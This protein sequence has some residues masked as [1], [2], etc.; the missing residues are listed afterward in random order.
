MALLDLMMPKIGL[1]FFQTVTMLL[2]LFLMKRLAWRHILAFIKEQEQ[3][4]AKAEANKQQALKLTAT[5]NA[6]RDNIIKEAEQ[7]R[8]EI[9]AHALRTKAA[10][11]EEAKIEGEQQKSELLAEGTALLKQQARQAQQQLKSNVAGLVIQTT[12]KLLGVAL[13]KKG[14]QT[15]LL[16]R[17]INETVKEQQST[18][19]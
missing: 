10:Y 6:K 12:E 8:D 16:Q 18:S 14:A 5:L 19:S 3:A 9:M 4:Y 17:L 7:K 13:E 2:V 11:L 15:A 1:I